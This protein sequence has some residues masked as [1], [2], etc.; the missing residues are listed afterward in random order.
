VHSFAI[1]QHLKQNPDLATYVVIK[2][3]VPYHPSSSS[4]WNWLVIFGIAY[5]EKF[6]SENWYF[7]TI[8]IHT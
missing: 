5:Q 1:C 2:Y 3:A 8:R 6:G 7:S 4:E